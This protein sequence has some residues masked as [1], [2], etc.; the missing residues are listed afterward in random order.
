MNNLDKY[1]GTSER[2]DDATFEE[3][4][5]KFAKIFKYLNDENIKV[6]DFGGGGVDVEDSNCGFKMTH[7]MMTWEVFR[8]IDVAD[9]IICTRNEYLKRKDENEALS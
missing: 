6:A 3:R 9:M 7:S 1:D 2:L 8:A 5:I 4:F